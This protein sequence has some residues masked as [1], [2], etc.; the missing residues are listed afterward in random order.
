VSG[1]WA[2]PVAL[3][4]VECTERALGSDASGAD[5][6]PFWL[7]DARLYRIDRAV[8]QVPTDRFPRWR[9]LD[10]HSVGEALA[11][12]VSAGGEIPRT[13]GVLAM[14]PD[15]RVRQ[16]ALAWL[17]DKEMCFE[18]VVLRTT[19]WV[20]AIRDMALAACHEA[21]E[22]FRRGRDVIAA[23]PLLRSGAVLRRH[24]QLVAAVEDY[25][26]ACETDTR[27][28]F[29]RHFDQDHEAPNSVSEAWRTEGGRPG[30]GPARSRT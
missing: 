28:S 25:L 12:P 18:V 9:A 23:A 7:D 30:T 29:A 19:D 4:M 11:D 22:T 3:R 21:L 2:A 5:D 1:K 6:L 13:P 16:Q 15:G 10:T 20:P 26:V 8:R 14:H 27:A 24:P 17:I